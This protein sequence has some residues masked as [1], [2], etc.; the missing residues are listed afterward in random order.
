MFDLSFVLHRESVSDAGLKSGVVFPPHNK[1]VTLVIRN[2]NHRLN[3]GIGDLLAESRGG[4]RTR[5]LH[6]LN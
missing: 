3:D 4:Q 2:G 6:D 5:C 1:E